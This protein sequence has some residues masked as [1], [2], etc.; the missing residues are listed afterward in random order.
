MIK[1]T[2]IGVLGIGAVGAYFGGLLC[3]KY[4]QSDE[5]EIIFISTARSEAAIKK[6]GLKMILP[7]G[8]KIVHP[9]LISSSSAEIPVLDYLLVC[10]KSYDLEESLGSLKHCISSETMILP[11]QNGVDSS[12]RIQA[13]LSEGNIMSGTVYMMARLT[14]PGLVTVLGNSHVLYFGSAS[15]EKEKLESFRI[16]LSDSGINCQVAEDIQAAVWEKFIFTAGMANLTSYYDKTLGEVLRDH[17]PEMLKILELVNKIANAKQIRLPADIIPE[18]I[19]KMQNL[20]FDGTSSMH[21][22]FKKGG[23]TE[24][25]SLTEYIIKE[26]ADLQIDEPFMNE[27]YNKLK[28]AG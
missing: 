21:S 8:Q 12:E 4:S 15:I 7:S 22:D 26:A 11:L 24:M 2:K 18:T 3:E 20:P 25:R 27:V 16:I 10:V 17:R 14:E 19:R 23:K 6:N 13:V 1:K 9:N 5:I 28:S